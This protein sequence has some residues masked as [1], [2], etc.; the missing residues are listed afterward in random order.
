[1]SQSRS[2]GNT[3]KE[4]QKHEHVKSLIKDTTGKNFEDIIGLENAKKTINDV[5]IIHLWAVM[6]PTKAAAKMDGKNLQ[7]QP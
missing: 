5:L 6:N 7:Q 2:P 3:R 1:M 4:Q